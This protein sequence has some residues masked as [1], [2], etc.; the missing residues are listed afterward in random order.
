M[1]RMRLIDYMRA[2]GIDDDAMAE[3][4]GDIT[5]HGIRKLKYGERGPSIETAIRINAATDDRVGLR[6]WAREPT[7][8]EAS[9][10]KLATPHP[11]TQGA[12]P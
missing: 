11:Q 6:D 3:R 12:H 9:E 1:P 2:E 4:V 7:A 10:T 5:A 8:P